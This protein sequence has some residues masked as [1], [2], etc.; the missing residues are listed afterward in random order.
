MGSIL[1]G[2]KLKTINKIFCL[3]GK[4]AAFRSSYKDWLAC[5]LDNVSEWSDMFI[6]GLLFQWTTS[7]QKNQINRV[8]LEHHYLIHKQNVI[9]IV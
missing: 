7:T 3:C 8:G 1:S 5:S 2:V 4:K 6:C 9:D